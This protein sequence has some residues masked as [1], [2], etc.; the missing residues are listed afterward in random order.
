MPSASS[1]NTTLET[2]PEWRFADVYTIDRIAFDERPPELTDLSPR[3]SQTET[4]LVEFDT[5]TSDPEDPPV[6]KAEEFDI[7]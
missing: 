7:G 4:H 3:R 2:K 5:W 6:G 1:V